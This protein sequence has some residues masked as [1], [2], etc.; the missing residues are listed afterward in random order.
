MKN[1]F[2]ELIS[3]EK[4]YNGASSNFLA[5]NKINLTIEQG[6][7]IVIVGKSGCGKSTLLNLITGI[8][9][10]SSGEIKV[11]NIPL[12]KLNNN[13]LALWRG[14]NVGIVF[15]FFQL[16][17]NLTVIEN[18]MLAMEFTG[19]YKTYQSRK[20]RAIE[21]LKQVE[22]LEH[23]NKYPQNM[24]GGEKQRAAIARALANNPQLITADEPTGNLDTENSLLISQLF[25]NLSAE[26]K[27][28]IYVTHDKDITLNYN[29][30]I[31]LADG[32]IVN[33]DINN[34]K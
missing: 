19:I 10:P 7:F 34:T 4:S 18:I 15:Q 33:Q 8:D 25:N 23:I 13:E 27:T 12:H 9:R 3:I 21:L 11:G 1:K 20:Q 22:L 5:L 31:T 6:D 16:L 30:K 24:S 17:P 32:K 14:K 26:G 2:I 29:R 28:I